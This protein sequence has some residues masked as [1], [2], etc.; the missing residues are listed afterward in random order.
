MLSAADAAQVRA[1]LQ[2]R[3]RDA[4]ERLTALTRQ[5][6]DVID[7]A[8]GANVDDEHDPEGATIAF[9]RSQVDALARSAR[10]DVV[11]VDAALERL[12]AGEYGRCEVCQE[13]ILVARLL[14]RPTAQTCVPCAERRPVV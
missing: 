12:D 11:A 1:A 4:N 14:V 3:R 9:E 2:T 13:P 7:A 5:F 10:E 6:Q 8:E